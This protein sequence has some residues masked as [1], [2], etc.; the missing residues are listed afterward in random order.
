MIHSLMSRML[1]RPLRDSRGSV[2][3]EFGFAM[4][5]LILLMLGGVELGRFV[6]LHQKLDRTAMTVADLVARVN[7]VN[8]SDLNTIFSAVNLVMTP[9]TMGDQGTV[10]V[11]S[12][13]EQGGAPFVK[14]QRSG[15]GTLSI[16]SDIGAEN[17]N[18]TLSDSALV[19]DTNGIVVGE[20]YY[21]Y[22]P[23]F[24]TLIP[25]ARLH[26]IALYRPRGAEKVT[27]SDCP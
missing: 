3:I 21:D 8:V 26:H 1:H 23:W 12:V 15:G 17:T 5:F 19:D 27:C 13:I 25:S 2:M 22:S 10:I 14:W 16:T 11:S 9:F 4:P 18:A 24:I 6:L 7:N 20:T